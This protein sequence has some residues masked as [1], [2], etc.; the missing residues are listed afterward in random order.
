MQWTKTALIAVLVCVLCVP[1][2]A[3]PVSKHSQE[4]AYTK[5]VDQTLFDIGIYTAMAKHCQFA[6]ETELLKNISFTITDSYEKYAGNAVYFFAVVDDIF[7]QMKLKHPNFKEVEVWMCSP[8][9]KKYIKENA[10][11]INNE[12]LEFLNE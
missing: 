6:E 5:R 7:E 9:N 11:K 12:L 2:F 3:S 1:A 8:E 4:A 10:I